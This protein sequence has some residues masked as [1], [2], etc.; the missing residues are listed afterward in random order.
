MNFYIWSKF[1]IKRF[2]QMFNIFP[3]HSLQL[4]PWLNYLYFKFYISKHHDDE[5]L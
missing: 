5:F 2:L 3:R 4:A 1:Q